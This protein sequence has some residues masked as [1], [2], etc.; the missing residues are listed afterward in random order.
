MNRFDNRNRMSF[1]EMRRRHASRSVD[2]SQAGGDLFENDWEV[3]VARFDANTG[4]YVSRTFCCDDAV[5]TAC[6]R[7]T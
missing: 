4:R 1:E 6:C 2:R 3:F 5:S 7:V